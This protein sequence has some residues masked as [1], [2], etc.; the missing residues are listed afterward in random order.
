MQ[1]IIAEI[2]KLELKPEDILLVTVADDM[3]IADRLKIKT[4]I[5]KVVDPEQR[6]IFAPK[7]ISIR[8]MTEKDKQDFKEVYEKIIADK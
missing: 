4:V 1:D 6:V 3:P 5:S 7:R 2:T 8:G